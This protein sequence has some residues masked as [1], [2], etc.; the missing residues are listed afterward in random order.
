VERLVS[1]GPDKPFLNV[2]FQGEGKA[3]FIIGAYNL[4]FRT[5]D[6]GKTFQSWFDRTEN[7][8]GFHLYEMVGDSNGLYT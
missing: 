4:I 8:G 5:E 6:G 7:P 2:F 3:G 1:D